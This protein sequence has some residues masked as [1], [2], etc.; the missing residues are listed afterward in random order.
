MLLG[1]TFLLL[2][3]STLANVNCAAQATVP[4]ES[5]SKGASAKADQASRNPAIA[6]EGKQTGRRPM[7]LVERFAD[8][9]R[10]VWSSPAKLR[11][12]DTQWL[13]PA[14]GFA[15]GLFVTDRD[16]STHLS[17]NPTTVSHYKTLSNAGVAALIGGAGGMWVLGRVEHNEHW[18]ETGFLSGEAALNSLV[19]V[20][21]LKYSLRRERPF[22]GDGS[23]PFFRSGGTSFPSEHAAAAWAVAGVIAHE[24]PGPLTRILTYG[25]ASAVSL[26]RVRSRQHFSSDV[27]VGGMIG[28]LMAQDIYS[29]HH[30]P[31]LGGSAWR[32][33]G[34]IVRGN[35]DISP[36]SSGTPYVPLDSWVYPALDR[37][38]A[39]RLSKEQFVGMRPWTR[40]ECARLVQ[41]ADDALT[42]SSIDSALA[43]NSVLL[44]KSEFA[45]E[46]EILGGG[47]NRQMKVESVYSRGAGI[48]GQ[49]LADSYHFGQTLINDFGRPFQ[50]GFN[51]STGFSGY[52]TAGR[53]SIYVRGEYQ[54]APAGPAYSLP[55]RQAIASADTNPVQPAQPVAAVD[56]YKLVDSYVG[57]NLDSWQFTF[58]KQS[59]WWGPSEGGALLFSNNAEPIYM[60]RASRITP[61]VLPWPFKWMGPVKV[62]FFFGQLSGNEFPARPVIHGEKISFKPTRNLEVGFSRTVELGGVGR[63]LTLGAIWNSYTSVT[64]SANETPATDPGKR[65]GGFDFTYRVPFVRNWLTIYTDSL[66]DDDPSPLAAPRRAGISTGF[67]MPRIP[68]VPKLDLRFES[69]YTDTPTSSSNRGQYIYFDGFYHDLYTNKKNIIGSWIGREGQGFQ[70]W[71][72][73]WFTPRNTLQ[74]GY[75]HARVS[76]DFIPGGGTQT[77]LSARG[78]YQLRADLGVSVWVQHERWLFPLLQPNASSNVTAAVEI[79]FEPN[80]LLGRFSARSA[81]NASQSGGQP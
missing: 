45:R 1:V 21:A 22:Q 75:R 65:T 70:G 78:D 57:V 23:G 79:R 44:L 9:Q 28:N 4:E 47:S 15:A 46:I 72:R 35:G 16:F 52:A 5:S 3:A 62:D 39:L 76:S 20:E 49:P 7:G 81:G 64:S 38:A 69:V 17:R 31:D 74:F 19:M 68:G 58:G 53:F 6:I 42:D 60:F 25:L 48:S 13:V 30:D 41:E 10:S 32:S 50:E 40:L 61:F 33:I 43:S 27:F 59:L 11:F 12:S 29:R 54:H 55:V 34:E 56:Q 80:Q 51:N 8:D 71:S 73:Y 18:S 37:L 36:A 63:P 77:D 2:L 26:S 14:G 67:Y 66:A 24:Y